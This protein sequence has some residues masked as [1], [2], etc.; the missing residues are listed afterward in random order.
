VLVDGRGK[1]G[2]FSARYDHI[3]VERDA[4][5]K[6]WPEKSPKAAATGTGAKQ[7]QLWFLEEIRKSPDNRTMTKD[8]A[9]R[10]MMSRFN[11]TKGAAE[12]AREWAI[13]EANAPAWTR[14]GP[15]KSNHRNRIPKSIEPANSAGL[16]GP[17]VV[18]RPG[19]FPA[20]ARGSR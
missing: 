13:A 6:K 9:I 20:N 2:T 10:A 11:I 3:R 1:F 7:A 12:K 19:R 15:G 8:G 5:L 17:S 16:I 4:V 14:A 18:H